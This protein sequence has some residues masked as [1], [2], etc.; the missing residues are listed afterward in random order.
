L[1]KSE[2]FVKHF[3]LQKGCKVN[4]EVVDMEGNPI[5]KIE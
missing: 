3:E 5:K 2:E 1:V 4:I